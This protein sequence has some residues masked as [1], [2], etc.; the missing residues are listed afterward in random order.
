MSGTW[1]IGRKIAAGFATI[2]AL[3]VLIAAVGVYGL[4]RVVAEEE[5]LLS[6]HAQALLEA[7]QLHISFERKIAEVRGFFFTRDDHFVELMRDG[8]S[9]YLGML[10]RLQSRASS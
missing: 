4:R 5:E 3:A 6:V 9:A 2:V 10:A 7:Q 8:R 1:T